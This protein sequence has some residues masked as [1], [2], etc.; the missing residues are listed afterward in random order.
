MCI[1][2][3]IKENNFVHKNYKVVLKKI[4]SKVRNILNNHTTYLNNKLFDSN[5]YF[6]ANDF[7]NYLP[8]RNRIKVK[9]ILIKEINK[10]KESNENYLKQFYHSLSDRSFFDW[11]AD[12]EKIKRTQIA[13]RIAE[14][15]QR[16]QIY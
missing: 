8:L 16:K 3:Y 13:K 5:F 7:S 15:E 9:N 11:D 4:D 12:E 1:A 14:K 10:I 2:F 6:I